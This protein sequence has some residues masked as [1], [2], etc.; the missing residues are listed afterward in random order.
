M[1]EEQLTLEL[2]QG[3]ASLSHVSTLFQAAE[4]F[5][6]YMDNESFS[7]HT[8]KAFRGDLRLLGQYLGQGRLISRIATDDLN[9]FLGWLL[10]ERCVPCSP[11]SYA[12]RVTTL[13]VFF[14]WL[15]KSGVLPE[16]PAAAVI[17]HSVNTPLPEILTEKEIAR[18]LTVTGQMWGAEKSDP[19]P[20]LL[21]NLLLATA[22]KKAEC[23]A[24]QLRH[25]QRNVAGG[26]VLQIRYADPRKQTKERNIAFPADI[27]PIL[28]DYLEIYD[29]QDVLFPCT[30]RNLEYVLA[31][32]AEK[33]GI[34]KKG[35]SFEMLRWTAAVRDYVG[36][37]DE[38][39]LRQ[40]LGISN[41]T[42]QATGKK[43]ETLA[44]NIK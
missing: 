6:L 5:E 26:P 4:V 20:H 16:D 12:R 39:R 29:P 43:I 37:M 10:R 7:M 36:G 27:L 33:A 19:R 42:W 22:I 9:K 38:A 13:K 14:K 3:M 34:A 41:V 32:V 15:H 17:Q 40:K 31:D 21:I 30:A 1:T 24:I 35:I 18:A 2:G 8:I 25:I 23:M 28:D 11:K 44:K